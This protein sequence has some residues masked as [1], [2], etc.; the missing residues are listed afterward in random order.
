MLF[1]LILL[2][3]AVGLFPALIIVILVKEFVCIH[4]VL[5]TQ[6][7]YLITKEDGLFDLGRLRLCGPDVEGVVS[8][9][10]FALGISR[11][12]EFEIIEL[13]VGMSFLVEKSLH[14][15]P[16]LMAEKDYWQIEHGLLF[17]D[18]QKLNQSTYS[19]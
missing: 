7:F 1:L 11:N 4:F 9:R 3:F 8:L 14:F 17:K 16:K 19:N 5:A 6:L 18:I 13:L 15:L 2:L 12:Y 10:K